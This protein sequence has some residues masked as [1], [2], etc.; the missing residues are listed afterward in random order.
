MFSIFGVK[1]YKSHQMDIKGTKVTIQINFL[2]H[3]YFNN[4]FR[5]F[6]HIFIQRL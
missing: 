2:N 1:Q 3:V 4:E 6:N 5:L